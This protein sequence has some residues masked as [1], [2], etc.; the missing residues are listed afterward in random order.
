MK[1]SI[2]STGDTIGSN[3][4]ND[5]SDNSSEDDSNN[6][7]EDDS[8]NSSEDDS[9]NSNETD[10]S[11][12]TCT[13]CGQPDS[14]FAYVN[15]CLCGRYFCYGCLK[16]NVELI[17]KN[18]LIVS[19]EIYGG[20]KCIFE[21]TL[22]RT[23]PKLELL[24]NFVINSSHHSA[25]INIKRGE[26]VYDILL[27]SSIGEGYETETGCINQIDNKIHSIIDEYINQRTSP[28]LFLKLLLQPL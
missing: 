15:Q 17:C 2:G 22:E 27:N 24:A 9:D 25:I 18:D 19:L 10:P 20:S 23:V 7:S 21:H 5:D 12:F 11:H 4:S 3:N 13:K 6:R 16:D 14:G 8:D 1:L 28:I 26:P